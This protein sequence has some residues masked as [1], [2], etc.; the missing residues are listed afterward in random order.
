MDIVE[1]RVNRL[2]ATLERYIVHADA[3]NGRLDQDILWLKHNVERLDKNMERLDKN[4]ERLDQ[5]LERLDRGFEEQ[6]RD[7]REH[8]LEMAHIADRIGRFVED[9]VAPNIP[10]I[11]REKFGITQVD[12]SGLRVEKRHASTPA[13]FREFDFVLAGHG[14]LLVTEVKSTA[15]LK[16]IE[17]F[18]AVLKEIFEYFPE[19][20][21]CSVI[22]I[23]ASLA[24]SP[25][26]V[27]RLTRL[28]IHAMAL[29][30][31]TMELLNQLG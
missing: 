27:R 8:A 3:I 19:H 24:L 15:H 12:F 2:E 6:K 11:A 22:P 20:R 28:K 16:H 1:E 18:G 4:M 26:F 25:D 30:D 10:R 5:N 23:F 21:G 13:K 14:K 7:G 29:S 17:E 31:R 9:I